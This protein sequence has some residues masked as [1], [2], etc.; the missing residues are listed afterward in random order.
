MLSKATVMRNRRER[1]L[2]QSGRGL[3]FSAA[4]GS[5]P[6][7]QTYAGTNRTRIGVDGLLK[8][9]AANEIPIDYV[10]GVPA[11]RVEPAAANL[12]FA[13][14]DFDAAHGYTLSN[15]TTAKNA[16]GPDGTA[17]SAWTVTDASAV[18]HAYLIKSIS[19]STSDST[20]V[21]RSS[22]RFAKT[23]GATSFPAV[24]V[25][26]E[27]VA[28]KYAAYVVNTNT[29]TITAATFND[30]ANI[31]G[32]IKEDGGF[33]TVDVGATDNASNNLATFR[34]WAAV[35]TD[36]S[37]TFATATQGSCV[38]AN[39]SLRTGSIPSSWFQGAAAIG[40]ELVTDGGFDAVTETNSYT[41]DF[42]VEADGWTPFNMAVAG[43]IDGIGG[44]NDTLR[45][46]VNNVSA[47]HYVYKASLFTIGNCFRVR[48][49]YYLPSTN[50][51]LDGIKYETVTYNTTDSWTAVDVYVN[52]TS[53]GLVLYG[54]NSTTWQD[55]GGDDVFYIK[56]VIIDAV[57]F[58]NWTAGTG[59]APQA[60]A[61]AL[62]GK[63]QKIAGT[64]SAIV[65]ATGIV[66]DH[67]YR[68][69]S[70]MT[71]T[72]GGIYSYCGDIKDPIHSVSDTLNDY[73]IASAANTNI[74]Y[75]GNSSF[76]GTID[77][78]SVKEHGTVRASEA[79]TVTLA[80]PA[81]VAAILAGTGTVVVEAMF[82]FARA[83]GV[84][85]SILST[86]GNTAS[87]MY[88]TTTAGNLSS[89]DGTVVAETTAAYTAN[90]W[91][92]IALKFPSS[93]NKYKI[94][95][96]VAGAGIAYGTEAA[97]DGAFTAG[98]NLVI[99]T[100]LYGPMWIRQIDFFPRLLSDNEINQL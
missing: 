62:T 70:V 13:S 2:I 66:A 56:D 80:I 63:A 64:A 71:R 20:T 38:I 30:A 37:G 9:V 14:N 67:V 34:V 81:A 7:V 74:G 44:E 40:S 90:T 18:A 76:A 50:S 78:V 19:K 54:K 89:N 48:F 72:G 6:W 3:S 21:F 1:R 98:A 92:K 42:S 69:S 57:T 68:I 47:Q 11:I 87:L 35:N 33:Y 88:T 26:F 79:G 65:Q 77:S 84:V 23:T 94:G 39:G 15:V 53:T 28:T 91:T 85:H 73:P 52:S 5:N 10:G 29:G 43:N 12:L 41:S 25:Q 100:A 4:F 82:G 24:G 55:V 17:N 99:G 83:A 51:N 46:T 22:L 58:T 45:I 59:W 96:D 36:A 31:T 97:F 8:S 32:S 93:T 27:G 16:V 49:R 61:G 75:Y 60:T 95:A 86:D